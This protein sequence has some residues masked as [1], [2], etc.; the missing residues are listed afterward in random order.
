MNFR[1]PTTRSR[2]PGNSTPPTRLHGPARAFPRAARRR[3]LS[4]RQLARP[5]LARRRS[6]RAPRARRMENARHRR[7][8]RR[9][10]AV[11]RVRRTTGRARGAARRRAGRRKWP[12]P[13][14]PRSTSINSSPRFTGPMPTADARKSSRSRASSLRTCMPLAS[15]LRLRG[16]DPAQHLVLACPG[17]RRR[18]DRRGKRFYG[19]GATIPAI[20]MA[21]LPAVVYTTGSTPRC[22]NA[23]RRGARRPACASGSTCRTRS[24]SC[25]IRVDG[26][27]RG[28]RILVSLQISQRRAG[29]GRRIVPARAARGTAAGHG[30]VGGARTRSSQ[31]ELAREMTPAR[32]AAGLQVG[33][34]PVLG[35]AALEGALTLA[36]AG[37]HRAPAREIAGVDGVSHGPAGNAAA[38][39]GGAFSLRQP[40]RGPGGAAGTLR[41]STARRRACAAR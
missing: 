19:R 17:V 6:L 34:P 31:F 16:L 33:T 15:H 25:R 20:Q 36:E 11:V 27:R 5:A 26:R 38:V 39:G 37:G 4:R 10:A 2:R 35:M 40:A 1:L 30:R 8:A 24:A 12:S 13:I 29:R 18:P 7:L 3:D 28:F 21:V 41:W 22:E 9:P 32:G 23:R 14:P